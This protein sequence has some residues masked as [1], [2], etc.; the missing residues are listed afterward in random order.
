MY[1]IAGINC[2]VMIKRSSDKCIDKKYSTII[3]YLCNILCKDVAVKISEYIYYCKGKQTILKKINSSI[4]LLALVRSKSELPDQ[5]K[6]ILIGQDEANK[7]K[8]F[9]SGLQSLNIKYQ[10]GENGFA[11]I[12]TT[13]QSK[14]FFAVS[15]QII[16]FEFTHDIITFSTKHTKKINCL[17]VIASPNGWIVSG[18]DDGTLQVYDIVNYNGVICAILTEHTDSIGSVASLSDGRIVSGSDDTT[19]NPTNWWDMVYY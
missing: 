18:S 5:D 14:V 10:D 3:N 2:C 15:K 12:L 6:Y 7:R 17:A 19:I 8:L 4:D 13:Y 1:C 11:N 16:I 9:W